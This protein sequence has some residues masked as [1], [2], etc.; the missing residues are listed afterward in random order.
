MRALTALLL[1]VPLLA[2]IGCGGPGPAVPAWTRAVVGGECDL[3]VAVDLDR[4]TSRSEPGVSSAALQAMSLVPFPVPKARRVEACLVLEPHSGNVAS[5]L[6][7]F[8]DVPLDARDAVAAMKVA[9]SLPG[10]GMVLGRDGGV[11]KVWIL[12]ETWLVASLS[13][14]ARL[15][16]LSS[17]D[18]S[19]GVS[20]PGRTILRAVAQGA[21]TERLASEWGGSRRA[22]D[23]F[24][25][26][27]REARLDVKG[28]SDELVA[29]ARVRYDTLAQADS[30]VA[31][32]RGIWAAAGEALADRSDHSSSRDGEKALA[33]LRA[34]STFEAKRDG[35]EVVATLSIG[36][37]NAPS[38]LP[39]S[40][41]QTR[42]VAPSS[43]PSDCAR[44]Q[45]YDLELRACVVVR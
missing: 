40:A 10:G 36:A 6:V 28:E 21:V 24:A 23:V 2:L 35:S 15:R 14:D 29:V 22:T 45:R 7:I 3:A 17:G 20:L 18:V 43:Y 16:T 31:A 37:G 11:A 34:I 42:P 1:L 39:P 32:A 19:S 26:G 4:L 41:A 44:G 25:T 12:D 38:S 33:I 13:L 9:T 5:W 27:L 30:V 8:H